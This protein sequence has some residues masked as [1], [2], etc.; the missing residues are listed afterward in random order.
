MGKFFPRT[1]VRRGLLNGLPGNDNVAIHREMK[2]MNDLFS[3]G[4]LATLQVRLI[5]ILVVGDKNLF[6][7]ESSR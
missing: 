4:S 6:I 1:A 5:C 7:L 3:D 2:A